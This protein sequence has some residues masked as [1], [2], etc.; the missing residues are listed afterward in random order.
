[1]NLKK[2]ISMPPR[3][4][5]N[6]IVLRFL[7]LLDFDVQVLRRR[8]ELSDMVAERF[9]WTVAYG[10]FKGLIL[11]RQD[12]GGARV[13]A[14]RI[15]GMYESEVIAFL[16]DASRSHHT[17]IDLGAGDGYFSVGSLKG[18]LFRE[19]ICFELHPQKASALLDN[20]KRNGVEK[21]I[22]LHG[23]ADHRLL[24]TLKL[25]KVDLSKSVVLCDIEGG[26]FALFS[27]QLLQELSSSKIVVEVHEILVEEGASRLRKLVERASVHFSVGW[28]T[29]GARNPSLFVELK[30]LSDLDRWLICVEGRT[31]L[32]SWLLL[33]PKGMSESPETRK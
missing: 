6:K 3:A 1:M 11:P 19:A 8:L 7:P 22:S 5:I 10:P 30:E 2:L 16:A 26:E 24:D 29:T 4:I 9:N 28:A 20:A 21:N 18:G 32:M 27:E 14:A 23:V 12:Q 31:W 13:K 33:E 25:H 15:L 17:L